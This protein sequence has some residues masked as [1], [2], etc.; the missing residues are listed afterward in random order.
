MQILLDKDELEWIAMIRNSFRGI[1]ALYHLF[2]N[3]KMDEKTL[4][5]RLRKDMDQIEQALMAL[6][7]RGL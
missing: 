7:K 1:R 3:Q 2:D 4:I 6:A 5:E